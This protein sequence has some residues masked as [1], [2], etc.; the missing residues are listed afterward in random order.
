MEGAGAA[1]DDHGLAVLGLG[2]R[3]AG[4][5][6]IA[7]DQRVGRTR[8]GCRG[9]GRGHVGDLRATGGGDV[10]GHVLQVVDRADGDH[11]VRDA[12]GAARERAGGAG[13]ALRDDDDHAGVD[14]AVGELR[15]R[16]AGPGLQ[17]GAEAHVDDVHAVGVGVL[18]GLHDDLGIGGA[19]AAE[20]AVGAE[21]DVGG[22]AG[23]ALTVGADDAGDVRAVA[24]AVVGPLVRNGGVDGRVV[25]GG[26]VGVAHVVVALDDPL[27][28]EVGR[29]VV[30]A[31]AAQGGVVV[32]DA[33]IDDADL[34]ARAGEAEFVVGDVRTG[35]RAGLVDERLDV[36]LLSRLLHL[37]DGVDAGDAGK[38]RELGGI[39]GA[40][41][42]GHAV[43]A[44]GVVLGVGQRDALGLRGLDDLVLGLLRAPG[45]T[46]LDLGSAAYF[47]E[48]AVGN[49][50]AV[51]LGE[52]LLDGGGGGTWRCGNRF[53]QAGSCGGGASGTEH[54]SSGGQPHTE[55]TREARNRGLSHQT[56]L[57]CDFTTASSCR[58]WP[59]L[60]NI[61]RL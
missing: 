61:V 38:R 42:H 30:D 21:L 18:H 26:V 2:Q 39:V 40:G 33:G 60:R 36:E 25:A 37:R 52:L 56:L 3:G 55:G 11:V 19:V 48:P 10:V 29:L 43:P 34:D 20:D 35:H 23:D 47:D 7:G 28:R 4:V 9:A 5:Q 6:R 8:L 17:R 1:V 15:R 32:V 14:E 51:Q 16:V 46:A 41:G 13:V 31:G 22:H 57:V 54:Q 49:G 59:S 44:L 12:G 24:A 45:G 27:V 50:G 58:N 53:G